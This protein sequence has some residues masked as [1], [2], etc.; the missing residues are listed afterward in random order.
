MIKIYTQKNCPHSR[1]AKRF[2]EEYNFSYQEINLDENILEAEAL[3][4]SIGAYGTPVIHINN[5]IFIGF[6]R[7]ALSETLSRLS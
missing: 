6:D 7:R 4:K 3:W 5:E 2:L 1:L